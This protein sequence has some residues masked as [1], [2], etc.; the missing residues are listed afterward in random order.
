MLNACWQRNAL[1]TPTA[2]YTELNL[3]MMDAKGVRNMYSIPVVV[4]KHNTARAASCWFII[5]YILWRDFARLP[6]SLQINAG[7]YFVLYQN[8]SLSHPCQFTV[9]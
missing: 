4:N 1:H 3:L 5:Y 6:Q 9:Q 2:V 8:S 7:H